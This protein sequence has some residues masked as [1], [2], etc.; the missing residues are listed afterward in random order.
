MMN[1][2][3]ASSG[4]VVLLTIKKCPYSNVKHIHTLSGIV[5]LLFDL[6]YLLKAVKR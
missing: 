3:L 5:L 2:V 4:E 1:P 6:G